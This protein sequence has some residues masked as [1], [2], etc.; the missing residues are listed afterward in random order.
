[1]LYFTEYSSTWVKDCL[2]SHIVFDRLTAAQWVIWILTGVLF[3]YGLLSTVQWS[4]VLCV[5]CCYSRSLHAFSAVGYGKWRIWKKEERQKTASQDQ[6]EVGVQQYTYMSKTESVRCLQTH[7]TCHMRE[8]MSVGK[9]ISV[10]IRTPIRLVPLMCPKAKN[11]KQQKQKKKK[12][13]KMKKIL[14]AQW[15][16]PR[17]WCHTSNLAW[18]S[19]AVLQQKIPLWYKKYFPHGPPS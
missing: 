17:E 13:W 14:C 2:W 5:S 15:P 11:S 1:M 16:G 19:L 12:P 7:L 4:S 8:H 9:I 18:C 6:F 3:H 10:L